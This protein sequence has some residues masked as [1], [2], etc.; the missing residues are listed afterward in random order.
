M[1]KNLCISNFFVWYAKMSVSIV[2]CKCGNLLSIQFLITNIPFISYFSFRLDQKV[3]KIPN[4]RFKKPKAVILF[5]DVLFIWYLHTNEGFCKQQFISA[6]YP[7]WANRSYYS[8][9]IIMFFPSAFAAMTVMP[10]LLILP[11]N[12]CDFHF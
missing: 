1:Y 6:G 2:V 11:I 5:S 9:G 7:Q 4:K 12:T 3:N 8:N 10:W